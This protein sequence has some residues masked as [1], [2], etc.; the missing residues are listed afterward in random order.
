MALNVENLRVPTSEEARENGAKGGRASAEARRKRKT[1]REVYASLRE[2][3]VVPSHAE[4]LQ[5][6]LAD[7]LDTVTVDEAIMLAM[8]ARAEHGDVAAATFIRDTAGERPV[9]MMG[10]T[11]DAVITIKVLE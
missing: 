9:D 7:K 2:M 10:F 1:L 4:G 5:E 3:E 6:L 8:I 11:D